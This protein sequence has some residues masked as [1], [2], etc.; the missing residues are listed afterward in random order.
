M[1]VFILSI[2]FNRIVLLALLVNSSWSTPSQLIWMFSLRL[3]SFL[4]PHRLRKIIYTILVARELGYSHCLFL[5][6]SRHHCSSVV[7]SKTNGWRCF[8]S[9][10]RTHLASRPDSLAR[11]IPHCVLPDGVALLYS[12]AYV[13]LCSISSLLLYSILYQQTFLFSVHFVAIY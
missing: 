3:I 11:S 9:V 10:R 2:V 5:R 4:C 13:L 8:R 12:I 7:L 1:I 6:H